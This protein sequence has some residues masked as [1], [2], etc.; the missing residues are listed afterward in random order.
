MLRKANNLQVY[1]TLKTVLEFK[2]SLIAV[3]FAKKEEI[4][5]A[6]YVKNIQPIS[7]GV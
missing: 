5:F 7:V 4:H 2:A 3:K 1:S 6:L